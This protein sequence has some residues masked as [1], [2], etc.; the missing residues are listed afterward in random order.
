[1]ENTD[2]DKSTRILSAAIQ[3]FENFGYKATSIEQ[4]TK[5]A[6]MGKGTFYNFYKTKEEVFQTMIHRQMDLI[7]L[8]SDQVITSSK[9]DF[10]ALN[11]YLFASLKCK[12][13]QVLFEKLTMEAEFYGTQIVL[14]GLKQI[15]D[16]AHLSLQKI[17]DAYVEKDLILP[18]D[19]RLLS[20]LM[21][22]L[23]TSLSTNWAKENVPL[24]NEQI[25]EIYT[26]LFQ[27]YLPR[28]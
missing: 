7:S 11:D 5:M 3:C 14:E 15:K 10:Q 12:S 23:F 8:Y 1:M 6:K 20:F 18:C 24:S 27:S 25:I 21:I 17:L 28:K 22:E 16:T 13:Q 2:Q 9:P 4:I 19:T 26:R